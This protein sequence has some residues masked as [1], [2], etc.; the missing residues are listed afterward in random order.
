[1]SLPAWLSWAAKLLQSA[2]DLAACHPTA[3]TERQEMMDLKNWAMYSNYPQTDRTITN[4]Y[5]S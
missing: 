1:M 2:S 3:G 5:T 4:N